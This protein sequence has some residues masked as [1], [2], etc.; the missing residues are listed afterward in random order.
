MRPPTPV[1]VNSRAQFY[2]RDGTSSAVLLLPKSCYPCRLMTPT[3]AGTALGNKQSWKELLNDLETSRKWHL[4]LTPFDFIDT[5]GLGTR[6]EEHSRA[7][8]LSDHDLTALRAAG[9]ATRIPLSDGQSDCDSYFPCS[10]RHPSLDLR[11]RYHE[12]KLL[13]PPASC[14]VTRSNLVVPACCT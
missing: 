10:S 6:E 1:F 8:R 14:R 13:E 3:W 5:F 11:L 4:L 12:L 9:R 7:G 2:A